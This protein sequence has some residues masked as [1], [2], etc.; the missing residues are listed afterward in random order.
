MSWT[1][2]AFANL[3]ITATLLAPCWGAALAAESPAER[4]FA[5]VAGTPISAREFEIALAG[6]IRQ[7]F[8]HRRPPEAQLAALRQEVI[9][10]LVN[11]VLLS[12]EAQRRGILPD[13]DKV[14]AKVAAYEER[15]RDRPQWR[16]HRAELLP[17]LIA[18]LKEQDIAAQLEA[19]TRAAPP[20]TETELRAYYDRHPEL[21]TQ[22]ER[23]RLAMILVKVDPSSPDTAWEKAVADA[24]AIVQQLKGGADFAEMARSH[25]KDSSAREG[26]D[27]GYRHFGTLP[28]GLED[29]IRELKI[30]AISE[31][32]RLLEGIAVFKLVDREAAR[33]KSMEDVRRNVAELWAREQGD[34]QWRALL[35]KLRAG[36][37]IKFSEEGATASVTDGNSVGSQ[38]AR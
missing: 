35:R 29:V 28:R 24:Q 7:K 20:P 30:G 21:F 1:R 16:E 15:N 17:A 38:M 36:A 8:Y 26:G 22:P 9:D 34:Q 37:D 12:K 6:A 18:T 14:R 25:S 3:G 11:R 4:P 23:V 19:A 32:L 27:L 31:P 33:L 13:E 5:I 2:H 10:R